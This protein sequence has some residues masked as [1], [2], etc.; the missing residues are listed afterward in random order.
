MSQKT[1]QKFTNRLIHET[2]PYLLQHAHNP[3][4]W[5][6]WGEEALTRAR[7]ENKPILLSIGYSACHWCHV[8]EHESFENESIAEAMNENYVCI[9]VDREERPD[10]DEIYMI[11]TQYINNGHG[12]WPMTVFLTPDQKPFYAGTYFPPVDN[13]DSP[14]FKSILN[15]ISDSWKKE[16]QTFNDHAGH[17]ASELQKSF[18]ENTSSPIGLQATELAISNIS[19]DFDGKFGGFGQAPKFPPSGTISFLFRQYHNDGDPHSLAMARRTLDGMKDGGIYDHLG[20]GFSRYSTDD[21]WLVP[22]FEKMLYDNALLIKVY[23]EAFQ[24]SKDEKYRQVAEETL[25]Y[26]LREMTSP[27][28]G[29]YSAQDADSEGEEGKFYVWTPEEIQSLLNREN[30][31]V[32]CKYFDVTPQGN[33]E[34][35]SILNTPR[36]IEEVAGG[37]DI[38]VEQLKKILQESK[39]KLYQERLKRCNPGKDDKILTAWNALMISAMADAF[40]VLNDQRY[41]DAAKKASDFLLTKMIR[42]DGRLWRTYREG[43]AHIHGFLEDH[44]FFVQSLIDLYESGA[45]EK[46]LDE[47][48]K[49]SEVLIKYFYDEESGSFYSTSKDHEELYLRYRDGKDSVLPNGN[50]QAAMALL[51]LS[52]HYERNEL[53]AISRKSLIAYG[54]QVAEFPQVFI[55][56]LTAIDF[57]LKGPTEMTLVGSPETEE[58]N[59]LRGAVAKEF[60]PNRIVSH[61]NPSSGGEK[62][63]KGLFGKELVNGKP[64]LYL[65]KNKSCQPAIS[66]PGKI[67]ACFHNLQ[68]PMQNFS[69]KSVGEY[70]KGKATSEDTR[71][72]FKRKGKKG[73]RPLGST[74]LYTSKLG[75]GSYRIDDSPIFHDALTLSIR[76]GCNLIDTSTNYTDGK[77][78]K[79]VG[80]VLKELV[81]KDEIKREEVIVVT[82]V[83]YVQGKNLSI[84]EEREKRGSPFPEM[85]KYANDCWHCIHPEFLEEQLEHSLT[86]LQIETIDVLLLHNPEYFLIDAENRNESKVQDRRKEF[87][88]RLGKAFTFLEKKVAEGVIQNYGVSSNTLK[89]SSDSPGHSSLLNMIEVARE[90]AGKDNHFKVVQ[91]PMNLIESEAFLKKNHNKRKVLSV[92]KENNIAVMVNRP[93]NGIKNQQLFRIADIEVQGEPIDFASSINIIRNLEKEW[94]EDIYPLIQSAGNSFAMAGLFIYA[95][96]LNLCNRK[97]E[98][99]LQW[100][101]LVNHQL[102]PQIKNVLGIVGKFFMSIHEEKWDNWKRRYLLSLKKVFDDLHRQACLNSRLQSQNVSRIIDPLL[103]EERR[104]ESLS[105]KALWIVSSTPGV[106]CVL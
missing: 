8:M 55:T 97:M 5:Y 19:N 1:K 84:S 103:P 7:S 29:F 94:R 28:G 60:V 69:H 70:L 96:A 11:A 90:V 78:E 66:D 9:K 54:Q 64:A 62:L 76:K 21:A 31:E 23:L 16:N 81:A 10:L 46:Y 79:C 27:E 3:V 6:P 92:A 101:D 14:G 49:L 24:V 82:K 13:Y 105:R 36:S 77:S 95:E 93:L 67:S 15:Q 2:S 104:G 87:Y 75:F 12:G 88:K 22:H 58:Y 74:D 34:G 18:E 43:K 41:F 4:E 89:E 53:E 102:V 59:L 63:R 100:E 33:W 51:R 85:V 20:G 37:L 83:G 45:E 44:A 73:Y 68:K 35:K 39:G 30:A 86:R 71:A 72:F 42:N 40:R 91:L 47:A 65:C 32:V 56:T 48:L 17:L 50:A 26:V 98:S 25:E 80:E 52:W 99:K 38:S 57:L 106:T 61:V